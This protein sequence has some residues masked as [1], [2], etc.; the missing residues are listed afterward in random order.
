MKGTIVSAESLLVGS[1]ICRK[2]QRDPLPNHESHLYAN[3]SILM[4]E[5]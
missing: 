1:S 2:A 4:I 3:G 5:I